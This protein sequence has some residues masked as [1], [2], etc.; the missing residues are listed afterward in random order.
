[1]HTAASGCAAIQARAMEDSPELTERRA[2][3]AAWRAYGGELSAAMALA[4]YA[5][6][7]E[8]VVLGGSIASAFDLFEE[9]LRRGLADFAYPHIVQRVR[10]VPSEL[11]HAAVLGAAALTFELG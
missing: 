7:P 10:I 1:M 4:L 9:S 2:A 5:Y 3:I 11:E 6:D 8:V